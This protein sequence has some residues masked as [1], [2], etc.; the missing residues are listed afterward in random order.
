MCMLCVH[1]VY[2]FTTVQLQHYFLTLFD[3]RLVCFLEA[4]D[5]EAILF[6]LFEVELFEP[7]GTATDDNNSPS[8]LN[9]SINISSLAV[10]NAPKL[11]PL[12]C[13]AGTRTLGRKKGTLGTTATLAT[14]ATALFG[15]ASWCTPIVVAAA[16]DL[17]TTASTPPLCFMKESNKLDMLATT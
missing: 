16:V 13:A 8:L 10:S 2:T 1:V 11:L 7:V 17:A 14:S 12:V 4:L 15:V 6:L 5:A 9:H 3:L